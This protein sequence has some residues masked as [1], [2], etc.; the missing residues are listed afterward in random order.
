MST[1]QFW[2]KFNNGAEV[3]RFPVN[4]S[5]IRVES[6][7]N[8]AT[9][10]LAQSG[11]YTIPSGHTL[12]KIAFSSF[13]P[14][15]YNASYCE[16]P[17]IPKPTECTDKIASWKEKRQPVRLIVTG[18]GGRSSGL[19]YAMC[20]TKFDFWEQA[21]SP[22]DIYFTLEMQ[23][24]RFITLR[25]VEAAV[26]KATGVKTVIKA[27]SKPIR[28]NEKE[29]PTTYTVKSGDTLT[30]IA[31]RMRTQGHKDIDAHKLYAA[32]KKVIGKNMNLIKP[33]QVLTIPK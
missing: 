22:G 18:F 25:P 28:P 11:E 14:R 9:I 6:G 32:N 3:L 27:A 30:K 8:W 21:G 16:Y 24:Y 2:L 33:G 19:N 31:Q 26:S 29:I 23:E 1:L 13:F 17:E 7:Y 10:N 5:E 12:T 20:I 15:D 4:P